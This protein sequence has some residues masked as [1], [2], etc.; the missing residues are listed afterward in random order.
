MYI[1]VDVETG[2]I[3]PYQV[4]QLAAIIMNSSLEIIDTF[5]EKIRPDSK[6]YP[7][8]QESSVQV[9][10][11][12]WEACQNFDT[13]ENACTRFLEFVR[14]YRKMTMVYHANNAFDF[15]ALESLF[16]FDGRIYDLRRHIDE[17]S[18]INTIQLAKS[19]QL[20]SY[21]LKNLTKHFGIEM[22]KHHD[23]MSDA[24]ACYEVFKRLSIK[25][26]PGTRQGGFI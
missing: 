8:W 22:E 20:E 14:P 18:L 5:N 13:S 10:G 1:V 21:S 7:F 9:H 19:L 3:R 12:A 2:S 26:L 4:I 25:G 23:A 17:Y 16:F 11:M 15:L 24:M 6:R